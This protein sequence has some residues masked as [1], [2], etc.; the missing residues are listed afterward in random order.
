MKFGSEKIMG[1]IQN[2]I[3][4]LAKRGNIEFLERLSLS[5]KLTG[6]FLIVAV[7][8]A[9]TSSISFYNIKKIDNAYTDLIDRRVKILTYSKDI[10]VNAALQSNNL[11]S[12]LITRDYNAMQN[13]QN[14]NETLSRLIKQSSELVQDEKD[15]KSLKTMEELNQKFQTIS[16][17]IIDFMAIDRSQALKQGQDEAMPLALYM[18]LKAEEIAGNQQKLMNE[19]NLA[20]KSMVT[21]TI[22]T[23]LSLSIVTFIIAVAI[24]FIISRMI[25]KPMVTMADTAGQIAAGNLTAEDIVVKSNDEIG[26]L[27]KTFNDMKR[28]LSGLI[29]QV[30]ASV[31]QVSDSVKKLTEGA[32]STCVAT[33][34]I[35]LTVQQVAAGTDRQVQSIED[36]VKTVQIMS[37]S[38]N[39]I[40]ENAQNVANTV[41]EASDK[42]LAGNRAVRL[43]V[44]QMNLIDTTVNG[45]SR[46][47][48]ELGDRSQQIGQI[49]ETISSIA[50]QTN[51][52][53]L[54]AAIEAARAGEHG[55]GFAVVADEVRKLAEQSSQSAKQIAQLIT[56]IQDE[57]NKVVETVESGTQEVAAGIQVVYA[58]GEAF[59]EI[60]KAIQEV[61]L[62]IKEVSAAVVQMT[63]ETRKMMEAIAKVE[64]ESQSTAAGTQ[65]VSA[66]TEEQLASI[67]EI[68]NSASALNSMAGE[69]S[70]VVRKFRFQ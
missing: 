21:A 33:T 61:V 64:E 40:S 34:H 69:L 42:A 49:V 7:I 63:A 68:S 44:Q 53:A 24:G 23:V 29:R 8:L 1:L 55:R 20:N 9:I 41:T 15:K 14:A 58:A 66:A 38:M 70:A 59:E 17:E 5:K 46:A 13:M 45:L 16:K 3:I 28:N 57:T 10:Q 19:G 56:A 31:D 51:L 32:E 65:N 52:L 26:D 22:T 60:Q 35:A 25:V 50:S 4:K 18:S 12:Y 67:E 48:K 27:A 47:V 2:V 39:Q 11:L 30:S 6:G 62:Q 43:A 54:N 36:T 37:N